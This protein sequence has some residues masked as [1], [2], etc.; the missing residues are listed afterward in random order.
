MS[1]EHERHNGDWHE[2]S[3]DVTDEARSRRLAP[4]AQR[5]FVRVDGVISVTEAYVTS[6]LPEAREVDGGEITEL[7]LPKDEARW[8]RDTLTKA[9]IAR[10]DEKAGSFR[11]AAAALRH[12]A[13]LVTPP[14]APDA[15]KD[16]WSKA[17]WKKAAEYL[18]ALP[19][20]EEELTFR[21]AVVELAKERAV[22]MVGG[23]AVHPYE[24]LKLAGVTPPERERC[25]R[26]SGTGSILS[27]RTLSG[28]ERCGICH[29]KGSL[30]K[31]GTL[32]AVP[33]PS[34]PPK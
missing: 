30:P 8:L 12:R 13:E 28:E 17:F 32:E 4:L 23:M 33:G 6:G 1:K 18:E 24:L 22:I 10:G 26:C 25:T 15:H 31:A 5:M 14:D 27:E 11:R 9:L 7:I 21:E 3:I 2:W 20:A 19:E 29:G 34:E 16:F